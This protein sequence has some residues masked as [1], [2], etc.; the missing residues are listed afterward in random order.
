MKRKILHITVHMGGGIGK[1]LSGIA[2]YTEKHASNYRH[3]ILLLD[4]P[5]K[6][7]F[8][9]ICR[10]HNVD[11]HV[12]ETKE[13][14]LSSLREADVIQLEWWHHPLMYRWLM[15]FSEIPLRLVIWSH[16]SGCFYPYLPPFLMKIPQ[17]FVFTSKYSLDNPY[18]DEETKL[19]A[20]ESC[21]VVNSSGGFDYIQPEEN[22]KRKDSFC[23]GYIGTQSYSKLHPD[24]LDFCKAISDIPHLEFRMVGDK[25]NEQALIKRAKDY[26][27]ADQFR[28]I[29]YVQDVA[30]ELS[31]MHIF[32]YL[33]NPIHFGTT[34]NVLLEAMAAELPV[35]CLNQ[36]AE[37]YLVKDGKTG[38]LVNNVEEYKNV[39]YDLWQH[40]E[41][42]KEIGKNAR[43]HVLEQY[44]LEKTVQKLHAI[45]DDLMEQEKILFDFPRVFGKE[46]HRFFAAFLP[47]TLDATRDSMKCW[48]EIL[49]GYSKS[50]LNHFCRTYPEDTRLSS[51]K[52]Q[53]DEV[54]R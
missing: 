6:M 26:G 50:S 17:R 2:S 3:S 38:F 53:L 37:K 7:N 47:P 52:E 31:Q 48:P 27:I 11:L 40:P 1:V 43:K 9:D 44:S 36:S 10:S 19:W 13:D 24:F 29:G 41:K 18:W 22:Q 4:Q 5:E 35:I 8:I 23:V 49:K 42:I 15:H 30:H 51:W 21:S 54:Q 32:G 12:A 46:P 25:T 28:F 33:L 16:V 20:M 14:V 39:V 45:Y 34:E